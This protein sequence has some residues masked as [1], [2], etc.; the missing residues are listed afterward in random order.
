MICNAHLRSKH[1]TTPEHQKLIIADS[2][3]PVDY[4]EVDTFCNF[5]F[6]HEKA[7]RVHNRNQAVTVTISSKVDV[8]FHSL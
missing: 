7:V 6:D 2:V 8:G 3:E 4:R 5:N 1:F